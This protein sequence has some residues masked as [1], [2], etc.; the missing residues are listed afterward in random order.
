MSYTATWPVGS[1]EI[2]RPESITN[3]SLAYASEAAQDG[4]QASFGS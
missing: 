4:L 3:G 2:I 1:F